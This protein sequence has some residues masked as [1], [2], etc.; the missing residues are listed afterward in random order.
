MYIWY[1]FL[2][3]PRSRRDVSNAPRATDRSMSINHPVNPF[4]ITSKVYFT[5]YM[6]LKGVYHMYYGLVLV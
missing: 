5:S 1:K 2:Q 6:I 3:S 4:C